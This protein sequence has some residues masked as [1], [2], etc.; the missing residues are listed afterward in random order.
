MHRLHLQ[1]LCTPHDFAGCSAAATKGVGGSAAGGAAAPP[2]FL[3]D[4]CI[5]SY[6]CRKSFLI[7]QVGADF[8]FFLPRWISG[9][10]ERKDRRNESGG[11]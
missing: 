10:G 11:F 8:F 2:L 3:D 5:W 7:L 1:E 9:V 6:F 4:S